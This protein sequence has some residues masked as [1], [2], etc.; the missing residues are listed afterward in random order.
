M[1][2][3]TLVAIGA[4]A[5][6]PRALCQIFRALPA[7]F[8]CPVVVVQHMTSGFLDGL[9]AWIAEEAKMPLGVAEEGERPQPGIGYFAPAGCHLI[10]SEDKRLRL[11]DDPSCHA[12]RPSIDLFFTSVANAYGPQAV[13][14]LLTG[15]G[16]DGAEGLFA[17][18]QAGGRTVV[19]DEAS[20]AVSGIPRAAAARGAAQMVVP[21]HLIA[22]T[23]IRLTRRAGVRGAS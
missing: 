14:V 18:R 3:S 4:S 10:V 9:V 22:P 23:L 15:M 5:G 1:S 11:T 19:Q 6:G 12:S 7:D 20:A 17:I 13:G 2:F 21:L 8:P 16:A